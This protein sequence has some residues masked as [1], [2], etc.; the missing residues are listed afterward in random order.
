MCAVNDDLSEFKSRNIKK[1]SRFTNDQK[2]TSQACYKQNKSFNY[3]LV[4]AKSKQNR[5]FF[6]DNSKL[7]DKE[8]WL[9]DAIQEIQPDQ[10]IKHTKKLTNEKYASKC[11]EKHT[12]VFKR[13]ASTL[14][15]RLAEADDFYLR[16]ET[17]R[18]MD[19]LKIFKRFSNSSEISHSL[20]LESRKVKANLEKN[21]YDLHVGSFVMLKKS[22]PLLKS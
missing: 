14:A 10:K 4:E 22:K 12:K 11:G 20:K 17:R 3:H 6:H 9:V 18:H 5:L 21:S 19:K 1:H 7:R 15:E 13:L 8:E 16:A 2:V